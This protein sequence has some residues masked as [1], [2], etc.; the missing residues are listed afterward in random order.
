[1]AAADT[2]S[3]NGGKL[4][5]DWPAEPETPACRSNISNN[6]PYAE[7]PGRRAA[8]AARHGLLV[9]RRD[10]T[11]EGGQDAGLVLTEAD[12]RQSRAGSRRAPLERFLREIEDA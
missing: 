7:F 5:L 8:H 3:R 9:Q 11:G 6:R 12:L 1:M 4:I 10:E 2:L